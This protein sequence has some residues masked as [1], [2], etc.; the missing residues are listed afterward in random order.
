MLADVADGSLGDICS[1]TSDVRYTPADSTGQ[2]N[3]F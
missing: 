1:A 2:R 3:T